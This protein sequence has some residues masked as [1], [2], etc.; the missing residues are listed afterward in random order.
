MTEQ[1]WRACGDPA[2]MLAFLRGKVSE[3][4]LRLFACACCRRLRSVVRARE[5]REVLE[6]SERAADNPRVRPKLLD[7]WERWQ[8]RRAPGAGRAW[9]RALSWATLTARGTAEEQVL[10]ATQEAAAACP[11]SD[12]E[13]A[14]QCRLLR[15]LVDPF[16]HPP[17]VCP[18]RTR[19]GGTVPWL[20]QA[21]Y[22]ERELPSRHLDPT[23]LA[24][25]ADAVEAAGATGEF[26]AHLWGPGPHVRAWWAVDL[27]LGKD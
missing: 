25:L 8:Y 15:D 18:R 22:D 21:A 20:A 24:I 12:R 11:R 7:L 10:Q 19:N 26:V 6:S 2:R 3:R 13:R 16:R 17:G 9:W 4:K 14:R 27:L 1:E 23:R 5:T